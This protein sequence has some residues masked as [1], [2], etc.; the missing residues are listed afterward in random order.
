VVASADAAAAASAVAFSSRGGAAVSRIGCGGVGGVVDVSG[1]SQVRDKADELMGRKSA[2][3][4]KKNG[5]RVNGTITEEGG[6][7]FGRARL[8]LA[9]L[10][11]GDPNSISDADVIEF[12]ARGE[13]DTKSYLRG[14]K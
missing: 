11:Q 10:M 14:V 2:F 5:M 4:G 6:R 3:R 9:V 12:L 13:K 1:E 7:A 8:R